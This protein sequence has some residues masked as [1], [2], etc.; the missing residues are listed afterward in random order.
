[1]DLSKK[2]YLKIF[3]C[4]VPSHDAPLPDLK[5][6]ELNLF[7]IA[8]VEDIISQANFFAAKEQGDHL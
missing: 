8:I 2:N 7:L 6:S 3:H 1:M 5:V 4:S